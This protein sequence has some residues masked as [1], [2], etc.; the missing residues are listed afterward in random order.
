VNPD[1]LFVGTVADNMRDRDAKGR[2]RARGRGRLDL[3]ART[4]CNHG[5]E[6]NEANTAYYNGSRYCKACKRDRAVEKRKVS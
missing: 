5:H 3:A 2:C 4:H 6:F 1:H